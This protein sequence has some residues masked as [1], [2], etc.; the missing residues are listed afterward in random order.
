MR[1]WRRV[2]HVST[3]PQGKACMTKRILQEIWQAVGNKQCSACNLPL[4][5]LNTEPQCKTTPSCSILINTKNTITISFTSFA[6][7]LFHLLKL[8][9]FFSPIFISYFTMQVL[10]CV[11]RSIS[12]ATK[13]LHLQN[14]QSTVNSLVTRLNT[15]DR[16][17][18]IQDYIFFSTRERSDGFYTQRTG[19]FQSNY[20][21]LLCSHSRNSS[22]HI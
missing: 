10:D 22:N 2:Q 1:Q 21:N 19:G 9:F 5:D 8:F 7:S 3:M 15:E 12:K 14:I 4:T 20:L 11:C 17:Q 18:W 16:K 13:Q 6:F